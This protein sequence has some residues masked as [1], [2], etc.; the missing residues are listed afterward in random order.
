MNIEQ[1]HR[2]K[3]S[4]KR[5]ALTV[6]NANQCREGSTSASPQSNETNK[7]T[8]NHLQAIKICKNNDKRPKERRNE[9]HAEQKYTLT[10]ETPRTHPKQKLM[11]K[12]V[13]EKQLFDI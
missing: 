5:S 7:S 4:A 1:A 8:K 12:K 9:K 2:K 11:Q 10:A 3:G 13:I 6:M